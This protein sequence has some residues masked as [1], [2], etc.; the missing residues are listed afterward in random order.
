MM[1]S[2]E[3]QIRYIARHLMELGDV[4]VVRKAF[5]ANYVA[6]AEGKDYK[7]HNFLEQ[8][9]KLI[10]KSIPDIKVTI[11]KV[12]VEKEDTIAWLRTLEGTHTENMMG[13]PASNKKIVWNEMI[14]SRF[15][16]DRI[17]EEW[18]VSELLG[19]L[20]LKQSFKK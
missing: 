7:G 9:S 8:F 10:R 19:Q 11:I 18:V 4:D 2:K 12:L 3:D 15:E 17:A 14:V 1:T 13:I 5:T 16:E 6:H 20:L